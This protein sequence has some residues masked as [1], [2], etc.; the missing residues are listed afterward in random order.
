MAEWIGVAAGVFEAQLRDSNAAPH[1]SLVTPIC[2]W[3]RMNETERT[4]IARCLDLLQVAFDMADNL[5]DAEE[6]RARGKD[7]LQGYAL[8]PS[9]VCPC[10]PAYLLAAS[11]EH[12]DRAFAA[13]PTELRLAKRRIYE[14]LGSMVRGQGLDATPEK[15][16][17]VSGQQA[18]LLCLPVWLSPDSDELTAGRRVHLEQWAEVWGTSWELGFEYEEQRSDQTRASWAHSLD[19]ARETW[20]KFGPFV[21][22]ELLG[23]ERMLPGM[24]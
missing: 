23:P 7:R 15:A 19:R 3:L 16:R 13:R 8:I 20:P 5:A 2:D 17:L 1:S 14:S 4:A 9:N 11:S 22:G 24:C 12:L 6:D 21:N 18:R 10:L